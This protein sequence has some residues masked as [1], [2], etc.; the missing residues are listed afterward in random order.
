MVR[1]TNHGKVK[2]LEMTGKVKMFSKEK[3]YG[4]I[5]SDEG[6]DIF[7]HYTAIVCEGF[8]TIEANTNVKFD[9]E[10]S[11]RGPRATNVVKV[12]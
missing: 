1:T 10:D 9:V 7:F 5:R 12:D 2:G 8:K 4:F 6:Q 3:G 11:S